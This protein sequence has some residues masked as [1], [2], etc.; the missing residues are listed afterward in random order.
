MPYIVSDDEE[1]ETPTTGLLLQGPGNF[2]GTFPLGGRGQAKGQKGTLK[3]KST[4]GLES[5]T[6]LLR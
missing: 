2:G 3:V 4:L 1:G 6:T 5:P